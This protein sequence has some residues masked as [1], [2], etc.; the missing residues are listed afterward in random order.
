MKKQDGKQAGVELLQDTSCPV[1]GW[2]PSS[3]GEGSLINP[4]FGGFLRVV[5]WK[6][7]DGQRVPLYDQP[8]IVE[9]AGVI[10]IPQTDDGRVG[11]IR[12]F[13]MTGNRPEAGSEYV[14]QLNA[15]KRWQEL[16]SSLG[17]WKW[18]APRGFIAEPLEK[19]GIETFV[20]QASKIKAL[21]EAGFEISEAK[22]VGRVN[23]NPTFF[24]HSQWVIDARIASIVSAKPKDSEIIGPYR[25]FSAEELRQISSNG[26]LDDGFT[27]AG[28]ALCGITF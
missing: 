20:L 22:L 1:V 3:E 5:V 23:P 28:L 15:E 12:N 6:M 24:A 14:Y 11:L 9:N 19:E 2:L 16:L 17:Q 4:K 26:E 21:E 13:R 27:L 25:F 10:I 8:L 18:E 7:I